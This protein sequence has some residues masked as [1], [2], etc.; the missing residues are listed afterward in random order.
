M[1]CPVC[2]VTLESGQD[3]RPCI[4]KLLE[5]NTIQDVDEWEALATRPVTIVKGRVRVRI[6]EQP[7]PKKE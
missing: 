5:A 1:P 3:H 4:F 2:K 7:A 6:Y